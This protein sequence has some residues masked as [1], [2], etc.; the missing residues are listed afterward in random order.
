MLRESGDA[1]VRKGR[2]GGIVLVEVLE[3]E[4]V[5]LGGIPIQVGHAKIGGKACR[6]RDE[7]IVQ[8]RNGGR[9]AVERI[10]GN[11]PLTRLAGKR[12]RIEQDEG[13][14]VD[15]AAGQAGAK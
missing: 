4:C 10:V 5:L 13:E 12:R 6:S 11:K 3:C 2:D 9:C 14:R 7:G 15:A 1:G 8:V